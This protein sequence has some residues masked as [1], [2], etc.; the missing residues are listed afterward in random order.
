MSRGSSGRIVV[1]VSP[2]L[3]KRLYAGLTLDGITLKLWFQ[4]RA[5]A[6]LADHRGLAPAC[7]GESGSRPRRT[8]RRGE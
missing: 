3:K 7:S 4:E 1:E 2:A 5:A 6:Y 8:K